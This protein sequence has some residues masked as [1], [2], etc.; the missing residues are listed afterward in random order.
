MIN[1]SISDLF[2]RIKNACL[3][4]RDKVIIPYTKINKDILRI[5]MQHGF[6]HN[7]QQIYSNEKTLNSVPPISH[8]LK[9]TKAAFLPVAPK[10]K[11][12]ERSK[13]APARN[14]RPNDKPPLEPQRK[15]PAAAS[16]LSGE[17]APAA[18]EPQGAHLGERKRPGSKPGLSNDG[19]RMT[20]HFKKLKFLLTLKY[21]KNRPVILQLQRLSRPRCR[22]YVNAKDI[23]KIRDKNKLSVVFLSTSRGILSDQ[24]AYNFNIGGEVLGFIS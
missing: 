10:R 15:A 8:G 24:E 3:V 9:F 16:R 14:L 7:F 11:R 19:S 22:L 17:R 20:Q 18:S 5:L 6:I 21:E 4:R 23:R 13:V 1:D 12:S 2:T